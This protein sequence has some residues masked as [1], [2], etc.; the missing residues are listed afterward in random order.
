MGKAAYYEMFMVMERGVFRA[1]GGVVSKGER[2]AVPNVMGKVMN[3]VIYLNGLIG[4]FL[5]ADEVLLCHIR[6][7]KRTEN[8]CSSSFPLFFSFVFSFCIM[9]AERITKNSVLPLFL[10]PSSLSS[11]YLGSWREKVII[12]YPKKP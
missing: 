7:K 3:R 10:S 2:R 6:G 11:L 1:M 9:C 12:F 5:I 4:A 8:E